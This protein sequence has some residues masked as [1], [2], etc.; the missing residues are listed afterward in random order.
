MDMSLRPMVCNMKGEMMSNKSSESCVSQ[1]FKMKKAVL[2][3]FHQGNPKYG[4]TA[5]IQFT[6]NA[7]IAIYF[8]LVKRVSIWKSFDQGDKLMKLLE[9][10]EAFCIDQLP[11]S[12]DVEGFNIRAQKRC[13]VTYLILLILFFHHKC[14]ISDEIGNGAIFRCVGTSIALIWK[15]MCLNPTAEITKVVITQTVNQLSWGFCSM[16]LLNSFI[17]K[18]FEYAKDTRFLEYDILYSKVEASQTDILNTFDCT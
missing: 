4:T 13:T 16:E 3:T 6:S 7:F 5:G 12:V 18:Y 8:S 11:L 1:S 10:R 15:T 17:I 2:G 14:L 9:A